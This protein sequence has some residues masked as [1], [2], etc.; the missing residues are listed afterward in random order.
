MLMIV[1]FVQFRGLDKDYGSSPLGI[2]LGNIILDLVHYY[3][4]IFNLK[5][6]SIMCRKP[7]DQINKLFGINFYARS[8]DAFGIYGPTTTPNIDD[9]LNPQN[10]VG[11][12][13]YKFNDIQKVMNTSYKMSFLSCFCDTH[14]HQKLTDTLPQPGLDGKVLLNM[15]RAHPIFPGSPDQMIE[16]FDQNQQQ[17]CHVPVANLWLPERILCQEKCDSVLAKLIYGAAFEKVGETNA[18]I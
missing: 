10:N 4:A 8:D 17:K 18:E 16:F 2:N 9:P 3:G 11:K 15:Q 12:S 1:A 7:G 5:D 14:N 6:Y 13:T